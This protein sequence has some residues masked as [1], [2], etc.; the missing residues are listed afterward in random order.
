MGNVRAAPNRA[1]SAAP[2]EVDATAPRTLTKFD[3]ALPAI[4]QRLRQVFVARYGTEIGLEATASAC[5]YAWQH[6]SEIE[7]MAN[8]IGYLFRV[9]QTAVRP[10]WSWLRRS[11]VSLP[12]ERAVSDDLSHVDLGELVASLPMKERCCVLL[13][14]AHGWSYQDTADALGI[15]V[16]AV[17]NHVHRGMKKLKATLEVSDR[18]S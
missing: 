15:S 14:H 1:N 6:W 13:V 11:S 3:A 9:G 17:T 4:E 10:H 2:G 12:P 5:A 16:T 7:H 8:P 18:V